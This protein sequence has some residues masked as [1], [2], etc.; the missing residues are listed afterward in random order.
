MASRRRSYRTDDANAAGLGLVGVGNGEVGVVRRASVG[1]DDRRVG[2]VRTVAI[3]NVEHL[4]H[5]HV[6]AARCVGVGVEETQPAHPAGTPRHAMPAFNHYIRNDSVPNTIMYG[7]YGVD[8]LA[9][10]RAGVGSAVWC[11]FAGRVRDVLG[12]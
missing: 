1:D 8:A 10:S 2:H 11:S 9:V 5:H 4:R 3:G 12:L 7:V 6:Q